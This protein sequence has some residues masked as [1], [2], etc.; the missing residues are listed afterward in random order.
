MEID[1]I[2]TPNVRR[3]W[4]VVTENSVLVPGD[5]RSRTAPGHGYPEHREYYKNVQCFDSLVA[6]QVYVAS[7][8]D[9]KTYWALEA[10]PLIFKTTLELDT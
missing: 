10:T 5:E 7:I 4:M 3:Y 6:M 1:K 2:H 8:H 9:K